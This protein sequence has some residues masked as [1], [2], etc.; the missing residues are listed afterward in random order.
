[1]P[2]QNKQENKPKTAKDVSERLEK[3]MDQA[4][5]EEETV[6]EALRQHE[7]NDKR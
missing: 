3:T 7:E 5:G 2:E 4:E 1:M 6:D